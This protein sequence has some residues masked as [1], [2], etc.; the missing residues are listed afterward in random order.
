MP[1]CSPAS[2]VARLRHCHVIQPPAPRRSFPKHLHTCTLHTCTHT[3]TEDGTAQALSC[4]T[5]PAPRRSFP[6]H[7]HACT[8]TH[9]EDGTA[10]AL[11]YY[12]APCIKTWFFKLFTHTHT[13]KMSRLRHCHV[14]QPP[15]PRCNIQNIHTHARTHTT[16]S[17]LSTSTHRG[18]HQVIQLWCV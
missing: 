8:H 6:L 1:G 12:S 18:M 16:L 15:T 9:T 2:Q 10:Q 11:S 7:L 14:I 4:Y 5:T 17:G 3:H 13:Q